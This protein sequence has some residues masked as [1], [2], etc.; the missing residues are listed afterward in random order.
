MRVVS[1]C[2]AI[3]LFLSGCVIS[4]VEDVSNVALH[5]QANDYGIA[6]KSEWFNACYQG[7][8]SSLDMTSADCRRVYFFMKVFARRRSMQVLNRFICIS[9][10]T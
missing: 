5:S 9:R 10:L 1:F 8:K 2:A 4:S 6:T 7:E 3:C